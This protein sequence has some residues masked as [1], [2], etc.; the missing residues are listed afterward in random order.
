MSLP[1]S[2]VNRD[3]AGDGLAPLA[4][5]RLAVTRVEGGEEILE[6]AVTLVVPVKLLVGPLQE[7]VR[8]E[9]LPFGLARKGHVNR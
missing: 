7:S 9:K 5:D 3:A 6:T 1:V 4:L 2:G 8:G